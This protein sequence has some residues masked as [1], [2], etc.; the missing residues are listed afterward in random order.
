MEIEGSEARLDAEWE[1]LVNGNT[2]IVI[3]EAQQTPWI[4]SRLRGTIDSER[5]RNGRFLV[6]GSVSPT[7]MKN[8]SESLAGRMGIVH[9]TPF[10]LPELKAGLLDD[11]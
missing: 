2:L 11:M 8:V 4:F 9:M 6:L 10:I 7:L 5:K 3:D 1:T